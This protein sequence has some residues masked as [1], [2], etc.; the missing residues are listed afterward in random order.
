MG[1][2]AHRLLVGVGVCQVGIRAESYET[3]VIKPRRFL[4][5]YF[6]LLATTHFQIQSTYILSV[7]KY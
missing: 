5:H 4:I 2:P 3:C 6:T 1:L 7:S